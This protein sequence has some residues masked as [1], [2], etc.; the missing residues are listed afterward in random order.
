MLRLSA[1]RI[2]DPPYPGKKGGEIGWHG[3]E[4]GAVCLRERKLRVERLRLRKKGQGKAGEVPVAAYEWLRPASS[5][6]IA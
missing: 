5:C 4:E 3:Q 6:Q 2:V 1:E